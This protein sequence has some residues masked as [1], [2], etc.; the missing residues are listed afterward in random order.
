MDEFLKVKEAEFER[1]GHNFSVIMFDLDH[2]KAVNDSYGH[3]AGDAVL[4][5]FAKILKKEARS[6]DIVGRYGGE[7]FIA[8]LGATDTV[9]GVKFAQKVREHVQRAR[10][11]YR[12]ERIEITVS[13][14]VSDRAKHSSLQFLI[15]AA[16]E[17]LYKAKN[18]GRNRVASKK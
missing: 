9:G 14:G 6:I 16:D 2:F 18:D 1:Y 12:G 8:L 11:I 4:Y 5:A 15:N 7:E 17:Y 10:F 3:E 13:A